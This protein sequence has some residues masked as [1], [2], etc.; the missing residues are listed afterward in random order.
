MRIA[1]LILTLILMVPLTLQSLAAAVGRGLSEGRQ[2]EEFANGYS[3]GIICAIL[4][5]LS[6]ALALPFPLVSCVA[7]AAAALLALFGAATSPFTDLYFYMV[8]AAALSVLSFFGWLG[9]RRDRRRERLR[10]QAQAE[11]DARYEALLA[12]QQHPQS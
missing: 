2:A 10:E 4:F 3:A 12:A 9:K 11:R 7:L 1:V 8:C 6:G 5:L